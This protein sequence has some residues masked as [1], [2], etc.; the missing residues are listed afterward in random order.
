MATI[1]ENK[2]IGCGSAALVPT[3]YVFNDKSEVLSEFP[4]SGLISDN[5]V[6]QPLTKILRKSKSGELNILSVA[7]DRAS[8][9]AI[10]LVQIKTDLTMG[11][12]HSKTIKTH[13][14]TSNGKL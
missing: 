1:N 6:D 4:A 11:N 12:M 10:H 5:A 7:Y 2:V 13:K 3:C 8:V 9:A 14:F